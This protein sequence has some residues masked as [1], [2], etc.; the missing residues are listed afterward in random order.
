[1]WCDIVQILAGC[2]IGTVVL[3]IIRLFTDSLNEYVVATLATALCLIT[4]YKIG[5][6]LSYYVPLEEAYGDYS[7]VS[8]HKGNGDN[9][10]GQ[11][12]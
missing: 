6:I 8:R 7:W 4:S 11:T 5:K 3:L 1:M 9:E 12:K 2:C 10:N